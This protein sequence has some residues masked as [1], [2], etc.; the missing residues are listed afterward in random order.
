MT[1]LS[2]DGTDGVLRCWCAGSACSCAVKAKKCSPAAAAVWHRHRQ[3]PAVWSA[4]D[5]DR[6]RLAM[7]W[8]AGDAADDINSMMTSLSMQPQALLQLVC[9]PHDG[10][11]IRVPGVFYRTRDQALRDIAE[12]RDAET[13]HPM[14]DGLRRSRWM[15]VAAG[16]AR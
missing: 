8:P 4:L 2:H 15:V 3:P 1:S 16:V 13:A 14:F 11:A 12:R 5:D 7:A 10:R 6:Q 9:V